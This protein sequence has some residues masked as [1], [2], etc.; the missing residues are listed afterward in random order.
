VGTEHTGVAFIGVRLLSVRCVGTCDQ[1]SHNVELSQ[2]MRFTLRKAAQLTAFAAC[3][4]CLN[5]LYWNDFGENRSG[6]SDGPK[7]RGAKFFGLNHHG[8]LRSVDLGPVELASED[9][10]NEL[11][12]RQ[13]S[14]QSVPDDQSNRPESGRREQVPVDDGLA[15]AEEGQFVKKISVKFAPKRTELDDIFISIKTTNKN[16]KSRLK[17]LLDTWVSLAKD[18][19][20]TLFD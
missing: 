19:V 4:L 10:H 5:I 13:R 14:A 7:E 1:Y 6:D 12:R 2:V 18:Q 3:I 11:H 16:H 15:K 17:L 20:G 8:R 9:S